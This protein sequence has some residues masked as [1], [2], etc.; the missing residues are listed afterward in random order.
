MRM[1]VRWKGSSPEEIRRRLELMPQEVRGEALRAA[2]LQ[3]AQ[4]IR[5]Q[6]EANARAIQ[7]TGTLASDIHAEIDEKK[8]TD[9]R[10]AAVVGPGK[11]GWYGRLVEFGHDIVVGGRKRGRNKGRVVGHVAPKPWLRPAGDA[12]RKEAEAVAIE[13]LQR[14]LERIW[15]RK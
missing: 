7:R 1:R 4:V 6:A 11:R 5:D 13:V 3:G 9:T 10:A 12:K 14:R 2:V 15:R 8:S